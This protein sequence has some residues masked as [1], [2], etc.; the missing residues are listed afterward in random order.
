MGNKK[1]L[2]NYH[3]SYSHM[4]DWDMTCFLLAK[5]P[6]NNLFIETVLAQV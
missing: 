6:T 4:L 1:V 5:K 3:T 2:N